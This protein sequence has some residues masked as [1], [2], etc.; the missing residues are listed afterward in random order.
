MSF[1][2]TLLF[3]ATRDC[4]K[5][6]QFHAVH[7]TLAFFNGA[8]LRTLGS[9]SNDYGNGNENRKKAKQPLCTCST[10]F[11]TFRCRCLT[12]TTW[13]F[14]VLRCIKDDVNMRK[15]FSFFSFRTMIQLLKSFWIWHK[16]NSPRFSIWTRWNK[17]EE[18][19]GSEN[20]PIMW[21][22]FRCHRCRRCLSPLFHRWKDLIAY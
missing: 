8:I 11:G 20:S 6:S 3:H 5:M 18:V 13:N 7:L 9:F 21:R 2:C 16:K 15:R 14:L 12:T 17:G 19:W 1:E 4:S 10:L 22:Q